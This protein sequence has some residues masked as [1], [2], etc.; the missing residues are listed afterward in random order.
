M[1]VCI[2]VNVYHRDLIP[3]PPSRFSSPTTIHGFWHD[4]TNPFGPALSNGGR[5]P[6]EWCV[7]DWTEYGK[8]KPGIHVGKFT[9]F[10]RKKQMGIGH[11]GKDYPVPSLRMQ[12]G[13]NDLARIGIKLHKDNEY[14]M[15]F[16]ELDGYKNWVIMEANSVLPLDLGGIHGRGQG[17]GGWSGSFP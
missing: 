13:E 7:K 11:H 10:P 5:I 17:T 16:N 12:C 9:G 4:E 15:F 14:Y 2:S 6:D 8:N 3:K 1:I